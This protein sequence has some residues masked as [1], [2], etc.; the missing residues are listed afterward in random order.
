MDEVE[1]NK[2]L[3]LNNT[4]HHLL[5]GVLCPWVKRSILASHVNLVMMGSKEEANMDLPVSG[6]IP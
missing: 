5:T 2:L 3:H 1:A 6:H 4:A